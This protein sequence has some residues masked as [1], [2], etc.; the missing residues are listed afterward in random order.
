MKT[1]DLTKYPRLGAYLGDRKDDSP[2]CADIE[3][4]TNSLP[5]LVGMLVDCD[6]RNR[7]DYSD[8]LTAIALT[9]NNMNEVFTEISPSI[10]KP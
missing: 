9:I 4:L 10:I 2:F 3:A 8:A 5:I 6:D 7:E 1:I